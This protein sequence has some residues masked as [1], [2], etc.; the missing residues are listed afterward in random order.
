MDL[1][2]SMALMAGSSMNFGIFLLQK[3][4][5]TPANLVDALDC[6][7]RSRVP[8]GQL[9]VQLGMLTEKQ[10][11]GIIAIQADFQLCFGRVAMDLGY[12]SEEQLG[13]LLQVQGERSKPYEEYLVRNGAISK[14]TFITEQRRYYTEVA[15]AMDESMVRV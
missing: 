9:A 12:L 11:E 1:D 10:V 3:G 8:M 6:E 15:H 13:R 5:V 14:S 7:Q 2:V 4:L